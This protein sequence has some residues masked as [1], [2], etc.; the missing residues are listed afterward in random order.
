MKY[1]NMREKETISQIFILCYSNKYSVSLKISVCWNFQLKIFS[2]VYV[3]YVSMYHKR[4][5]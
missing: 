3:F 4:N 2:S 1:N 5:T